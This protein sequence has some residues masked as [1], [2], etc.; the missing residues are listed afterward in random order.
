[1]ALKTNDNPNNYLGGNAATFGNSLINA[2]DP[3]PISI[4]GWIRHDGASTDLAYII[5]NSVN[6]DPVML[7]GFARLMGGIYKQRLYSGAYSDSD[8]IA[9]GMPSDHWVHCGWTWDTDDVLRFYFRGRPNGV[10]TRAA[11]GTVSE[12]VIWVG[13]GPLGGWQ[14]NGS[15]GELSCWNR[16]V[17]PSEMGRLG[18][19]VNPLDLENQHSLISYVLPNLGTALDHPGVVNYNFAEL[20]YAPNAQHRQWDV[21]ANSDFLYEP[22]LPPVHNPSI[23]LWNSPAVFVPVVVG[24]TPKGVFDNVFAGPFGGPIG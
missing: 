8:T 5:N 15:V 16:I 22:Y 19:G 14:V 13:S 10:T 17:S 3:R 24:A 21:N 11:G 12:G 18:L 20:D 23:R 4:S 7:C 6:S 1:M 2:T 9:G